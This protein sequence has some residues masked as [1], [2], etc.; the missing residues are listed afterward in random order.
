MTTIIRSYAGDLPTLLSEYQT[1]GR[2]EGGKLRPPSDA[3]GLDSN[4]GELLAE[5]NKRA[6]DENNLLETAIIESGRVATGCRDTLANIINKSRD[7]LEDEF[8][9]SRIEASL[10]E[11]R[12]A[13]ELV[14]ERR[15]RLEAE[16][17]WFRTQNEI[18][19]EAVYPES[20][21]YHFGI[22]AVILLFE[23]AVN[24]F[25]YRNQSG[26]LG[27]FIVAFTISALS[28][29]TAAALGWAFRFKNLS[30][31]MSKV[32]GW[33]AFVLFVALTIFFAALFA[34]FRS[35]YQLLVD[36][37][38]PQQLIAAFG[39]AWP[40]ALS[41]FTLRF[42]FI[43]IFS[44]L[45]F[46]MTL[47]LSGFAFYKGYTSDDKHPG[48]SLK[49]RALKDAVAAQNETEERIRAT[50]KH[51]LD[52]ARAI[53]ESLIQEFARL[54][55]SLSGKE[56]SLHQARVESQT[57]L[58]RLA[59]DFKMVIEAYRHAN[60]S[61]RTVPPPAYFQ[62]IPALVPPSEDAQF[63][64][65]MSLLRS[66]AEETRV[67][68]ASLQEKLSNKR[69]DLQTLAAR[70]LNQRLKEYFIEIQKDVQKNIARSTT[71]MQRLGSEQD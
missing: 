39:K 49:A 71:T 64:N 38:D 16:Y 7:F 20:R 19:E 33:A 9:E 32:S 13:Q 34:S 54:L 42:H 8:L 55:A 40:L 50:T 25:F 61:T 12:H 43:D 53:A 47:L 1:R 4:E 26:L 17:N 23:A 56:A 10:S 65:V 68:Q 24:A 18:Q 35:E 46:W 51:M 31:I 52:S 5:A 37:S 44:F 45:L 14:S 30:G 11:S 63:E 29:G 28:L 48:Y 22:V 3:T 57:R 36:P 67:A 62:T 60:V 15:L 2:K 70:V 59:R 6:A 21:L 66:V 69:H 41:I 27:G 58:D